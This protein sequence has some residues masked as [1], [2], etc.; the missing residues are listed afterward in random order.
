MRVLFGLRRT[1]MFNAVTEAIVDQDEVQEQE[2]GV[3][4]QAMADRTHA[5]AESMHARGMQQPTSSPLEYLQLENGTSN[6]AGASSSGFS[7]RARTAALL[8]T[9]NLPKMV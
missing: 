4:R 5:Q 9:G 3:W 2:G 8:E 7:A 1:E 6:S